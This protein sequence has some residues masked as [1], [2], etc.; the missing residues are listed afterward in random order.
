MSFKD[1]LEMRAR[2]AVKRPVKSA[3]ALISGLLPRGKKG[4]TITVLMYHRVNRFRKN[5][6]SVSPSGFERQV[7]HLRQSGY[8]NMRLEDLESL[9]GY[10]GNEDPRVIFSFDDGYEDNFTNAFP[11]LKKYGYTAIFY[12][13]FNFIETGRLAD[14]DAR[15]TGDPESNRRLS[16]RQIEELLSERMEIGSHTMNHRRLV[17]MPDEEAWMEISES[18]WR[19]EEKLG[20]EIGSFCYPGGFFNERHVE[21]VIRAGYRSACTAAPGAID[22]QNPFEIPRLAVQASDGFVTFKRKIEGRMAWFRLI[23]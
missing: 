20:T 14:R 7:A 15:E 19:L 12:V 3:A 17:D 18:K 2:I 16:W 10:A 6:M 13:P 4:G 23:R 5:D 9:V 22:F 11:I 1:A 21:M 8:R